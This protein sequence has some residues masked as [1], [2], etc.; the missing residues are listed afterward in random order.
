MNIRSPIR[1]QDGVVSGMPAFDI[2]SSQEIPNIREYMNSDS[3]SGDNRMASATDK[4]AEHLSPVNFQTYSDE[5][6]IKDRKP[7]KLNTIQD[8]PARTNPHVTS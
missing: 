4:K 2:Q 7:F 6:D 3:A 8:S 1:M 5:G